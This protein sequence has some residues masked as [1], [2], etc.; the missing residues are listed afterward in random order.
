[1]SKRF[2]RNQR[3]AMRE[4]IAGLEVELVQ[5][6]RRE[7][8]ATS[9]YQDAFERALEQVVSKEDHYNHA[10]RR[11]SDELAKAFPPKLYEAAKLLMDSRRDGPPIRFTAT[12]QPS[13]VDGSTMVTVI[14]G[15]I[16]AL[17]YSVQVI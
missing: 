8:L 12:V 5:T 9:R 10:I 16:P 17:R 4:R 1:M 14:R 7:R 11:I 3:R 6:Q 13:L 2:G 15:E